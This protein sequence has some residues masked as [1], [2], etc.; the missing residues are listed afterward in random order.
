MAMTKGLRMGRLWEVNEELLRFLV[1][2][3]AEY[4]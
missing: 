1:G 3:E 2:E 4:G